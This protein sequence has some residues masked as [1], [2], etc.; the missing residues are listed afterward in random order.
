[1]VGIWGGDRLPARA[2][3]LG[4]AGAQCS[5]TPERSIIV[6]SGDVIT[7]IRYGE[8]LISIF[9]TMLPP[10]WLYGARMAASIWRSAYTRH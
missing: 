5:T 8:L 1:M 6:T 2:P 10:R 4:T 9:A 7:D 3:P